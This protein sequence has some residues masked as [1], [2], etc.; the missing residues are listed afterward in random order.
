MKFPLTERQE[1]VLSF[2]TEF[3]E[4]NE[5]PPT[6]TE[7]QAGVGIDNPGSVYGT[8]SELEKKEYI[9]KKTKHQARNIR[10]TK[11]GKSLNIG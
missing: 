3:I 1:E 8:L 9:R 11:N 5:Y 7:I 6:I 2:I 10:L 4:K